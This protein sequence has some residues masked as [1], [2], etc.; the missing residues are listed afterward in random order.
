MLFFINVLR[1]SLHQAVP[2]IL[3]KTIHVKFLRHRCFFLTQ[4]FISFIIVCIISI[5]LFL[6]Q[7]S[8]LNWM[9]LS[10]NKVHESYDSV[11]TNLCS[12]ASFE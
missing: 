8:G 9:Q 2:L 5:C 4:E 10:S 3:S 12:L 11:S 1:A 6:R 7:S